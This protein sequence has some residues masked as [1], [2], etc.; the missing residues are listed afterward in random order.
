MWAR[1]DVRAL[2]AVNVDSLAA[3]LGLAP[4]ILSIKGSDR[5]LIPQGDRARL[6][7][8][9]ASVDAVVLF[10]EETPLELIK[11]LR[12]DVLAKGADYP[13]EQVVGA[14][15]VRSWGGRVVLVPLV[16]GR[17]TSAILA[18]LRPQKAN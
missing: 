17:S 4:R 9:L 6:L 7:A 10:D 12:P 3:N 2:F 15:E 8:A 16:D 14:P 5:P 18:H 1:P 13:E 11:G